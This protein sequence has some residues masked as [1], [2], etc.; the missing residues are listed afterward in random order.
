MHIKIWL[1]KENM[2]PLRYYTKSQSDKLSEQIQ[3]D[4]Y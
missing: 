2:S 3:N 1:T 4:K